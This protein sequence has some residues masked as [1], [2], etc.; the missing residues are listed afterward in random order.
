MRAMKDGRG[1]ERQA[2]DYEDAI[3]EI[4]QQLCQ[5]DGIVI[6]AG[7]GLSVSAGLAYDGPRFTENFGEFIEKY[8]MTDMYSAGFYP[9]RTQEEKW[10]YWSRHIYVNRYDTEAGQAYKD[11]YVLL[12]DKNY[13]VITTNVDHQFQLAGFPEERIFATQGDYG[14]FQCKRACHKTL[15]DNEAQVR[16]MIKHQENCRIPAQ[17]V[18]KCPV[19]GGDMEVNLRSDGY[20]V[21]DESWHR[22]AERYEDFL[23]KNL[24]KKLVF[25]EL[26]V[27]MNTPVIIKYPFWKMT[28]RMKQASYICINK[29]EA[30][31]PEEIGERSICMNEDIGSVLKDLKNRACRKKRGIMEERG[32]DVSE[33]V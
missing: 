1:W 14:L 22:A 2:Q 11:L 16:A 5:A 12:K 3:R 18:P 24:R 19:C 26:G 4:G 9:F 10:A 29:G 28:K 8:K 20:F 25:V 15:Y 32:A 21:E 27:G 6:G 13:F 23:N 30:W 7:A 33:T 17:L 31:A